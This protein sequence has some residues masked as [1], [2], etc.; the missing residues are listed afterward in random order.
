MK[1]TQT[2]RVLQYL[3]TH[4]KCTS[5]ELRTALHVVDIPK[6][7]SILTHKGFNITARRLKDNTSEY[8]LNRHGEKPQRRVI[9]EGNKAIIIDE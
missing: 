8:Q 9:F 3:R 4:G 7:I 5:N 1:I 6:C 2:E